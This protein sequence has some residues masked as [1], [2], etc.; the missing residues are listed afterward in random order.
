MLGIL[1]RLP[2]F[3]AS[4]FASRRLLLAGLVAAVISV[5]AT[6]AIRAITVSV[7]TIPSAFTPL[8]TS[9]VVFLTIV[10]VIGA[11]VA[12]LT[13]NAVAAQPVAVFRR[14]VPAALALSFI[15]DAAIWLSRSYQHTARASTVIPL[16]V[17]HIV[18]AAVCL[19]SL[20]GLGLRR[21][22]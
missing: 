11:T 6:V 4:H 19:T 5:I 12:C 9:S 16:L 18:V 3:G 14:V 22:A 17:M 10:G 2:S 13:L 1:P 21:S 15:P 20:V 7:E 8:H